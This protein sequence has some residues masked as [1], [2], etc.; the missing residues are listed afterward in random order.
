MKV[1]W[2]ANTPSLAEEKL[3]KIPVGGGWIKSLEKEIKKNV[4]I[5]LGIAF[6][7]RKKIQPFVYNNTR[8]FPIYNKNNTKIKR[9]FNRIFN[10]T[11]IEEEIREYL[12]I[13]ENFKPEI[14]H[15]HGTELPFGLIQEVINIPVVV[16]IQ[17]NLNVYSYKF[18]SGISKRDVKRYSKIMNRIFFTTPY[19]SYKKFEAKAL[20]ERKI[21]SNTK[22]IIGRTNWDYRI[23]RILAKNSTYYH[24]DEILRDGFYTNKWNYKLNLNDTVKIYTTNGPSLYK[25]IE[26]ILYTANL[27]DEYGLD[28]E[29]N[30]AGLLEN[31]NLVRIAEK[32]VRLKISKN[33]KFLGMIEEKRLIR[34]LLD[35]HFYIM[36]SHIENSPNNL[37]EAMIL[38]M[39][40]IATNAGGTGSLLLDRHNGILVQ[41][42]DPYVLSGAIIE[43]IE[44]FSLAQE[45]GKKARQEALQR[46]DRHKI[47]KELL[48]IYNSCL[49]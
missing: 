30:I 24:N 37:C 9:L 3:S 46:H 43:M 33:I 29:W 12:R 10:F 20:I 32:S 40:C 11:D 16:S 13:I 17:G 1:L 19:N 22:N 42:G 7:F 48:Q 31:D 8:Y 35:S 5:E 45:Y 14:I 44:N 36:P 25:G 4:D 21:L 27:L 15:I 2:F 23:T 39:P 41:D 34:V 47:A 49:V 26:T 18:F 28:Y 6:Y 38:G